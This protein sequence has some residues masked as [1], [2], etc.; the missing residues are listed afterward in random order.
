[1][2]ELIRPTS[3]ETNPATIEIPR[4]RAV[5]NGRVISPEDASYDEARTV[6]YGGFDRH[7]AVIVRVKDATEVSRVIALARAIW[8]SPSRAAAIA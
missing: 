7:P 3:T 5:L 1:M 2:S 4:L 6:F 8:S